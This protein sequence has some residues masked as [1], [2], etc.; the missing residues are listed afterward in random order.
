MTAP[1]AVFRTFTPCPEL[2]RYIFA[3]MWFTF[4]GEQPARTFDRKLPDGTIE[5]RFNLADPLLTR[6]LP[7][8]CPS[9]SFNFGDPWKLQKGSRAPMTLLT[10]Y[11]MGP[12]TRPGV[13]EFGRRAAALGVMFQP[14]F[15]GIFLNASADWLTDEIVSLDDLW[16]PEA[17]SLEVYLAGLRSVPEKIRALE[18]ELLRRLHAARWIDTSL[19]PITDLIQRERGGV[20]VEWLSKASGLSRQHLTRKFRQQVGVTPKQYCRFARFHA[21]LNRVYFHS[22]VNWASVAAEYG[23]YDQA[24]LI[25][26]FKK[27]TGLTPSQ[28]FLPHVDALAGRSAVAAD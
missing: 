26:E 23:Y 9:L 24:H 19:Q 18:K 1:A 10:R 6:M 11:V 4:E 5:S 8:G 20:S 25:A 28:F 13:V 15:A 3:Y 12:A 27:F 17:K 2:R 16:G 22:Q 7:G 21:L 14:T